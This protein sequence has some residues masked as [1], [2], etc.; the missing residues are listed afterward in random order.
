MKEPFTLTNYAAVVETLS[1]VPPSEE[2]IFPHAHHWF[3]SIELLKD[4]RIPEGWIEKAKALKKFLRES[5]EREY[6]CHGDLHFENV[7]SHGNRF[8]SIDPKG[9][10]GE[11]AFEASAFDLFSPEELG[12]SETLSKIGLD[13]IQ[14]LSDLLQLKPE[15]L[16]AWIFLRILLSIQWSLEDRGD[17]GR[18][19]RI[20]KLVFPLFE[21]IN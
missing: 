11:I 17:P 12:N 7:L 1:K 2:N 19:I 16:L 20:G 9:I 4:P 13:R 3:E 6:L 5:P 21:N 18:M 8:V 14:K 15:R 10:I